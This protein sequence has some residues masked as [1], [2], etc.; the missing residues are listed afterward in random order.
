MTLMR[1]EREAP[2][3]HGVV[4]RPWLLDWHTQDDFRQLA[5]EA[6]FRVAAVRS[7]LGQPATPD[8]R[9]FVFILTGFR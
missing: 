4:D 3:S 5:T 8:D 9:S 2:G 6:G 7:P 1:C